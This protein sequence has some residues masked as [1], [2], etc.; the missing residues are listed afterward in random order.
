MGLD[1]TLYKKTYIWN[2]DRKNIKITTKGEASA[3]LKRTIRD[4]DLKN[5]MYITEEAGY[6]RKAN[7]IHQWFVDNVQNGE[8]DCGTYYV[9]TEK[10]KELRRLCREVLRSCKLVDSGETRK[11]YDLDKGE[12]VEEKVM[13]IKDTSVAEELLPTQEGFFFGGTGYD[14]YYIQNLEDT[15]VII[16]KAL[17]SPAAEFEYHSSW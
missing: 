14:E 17:E 9:S 7:Q 1:M 11:V 15:I 16:D 2:E 10:L 13:K 6:W 12:E 4:I 5:V 3:S 8:D